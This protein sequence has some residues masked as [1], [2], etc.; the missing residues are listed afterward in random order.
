MPATTPP[1]IRSFAG[2]LLSAALA[3]L[4]WIGLSDRRRRRQVRH[5]SIALFM[6]VCM[7]VDPE[8]V[9]AMNDEAIRAHAM[10]VA[11]I[12][13]L[14][15]TTTTFA[16]DD[17]GNQIEK[18]LDTT[19]TVYVFDAENRLTEF[20]PLGQSATATYTYDADGVRNSKTVSGPTTTGYLTDKN[21]PYA[22]VIEEIDTTTP[23]T[24]TVLMRYLYGDD[25]ISQTADPDGMSPA[26]SF[27]HYDG[28]MSTRQLTDDNGS[29]SAV[30]DH[31]KYD[32]FGQQLL[33]TPGSTANKYLYT[34]E[35]YDSDLGQYYLRARYYDQGNGRFMSRDGFA[36]LMRDPT[37]LHK[38]AYAFVDPV[39]NSDPSG[40]FPPSGSVAVVAIVALALLV[41][42]FVLLPFGRTSSVAL[43]PTGTFVPVNRSRLQVHYH[44]IQL[45]DPKASTYAIFNAMTR[46]AERNLYPVQASGN[47]SRVGGDVSFDMI[48]WLPND[49]GQGDFSVRVTQFNRDQHYFVVRTLIGHP[50]AGWRYWGVRRLRNGDVLIETFAVIHPATSI[51]R[52]KLNFLGGEEGMS[53]TWTNMLL[54]LMRWSGARGMRSTKAS[55]PF[56]ERRGNV[57]P[58]LQAVDP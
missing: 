10:M 30:T 41:S 5:S 1:R 22:Q 42:V 58:Y 46:L 6:C 26:T 9:Y 11:G 40:L 55:Q 39:N 19:T 2:L 17:N 33:A 29:S 44:S 8:R 35:Q 34:G 56:G 43:G 48:P 12:G 45:A 53:N 23:Q 14:G 54:D 49:L 7:S 31:Y 27:F 50:L 3:P 51:D 52:F 37:S 4:G 47:A 18:T 16:Y 13:A 21:R 38:Y 36:G 57:A 20:G 15:E 28:Q 32:A 25:L 24:P